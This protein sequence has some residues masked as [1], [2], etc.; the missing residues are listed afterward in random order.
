M[1]FRIIPRLWHVI[2]DYDH[3]YTEF[4]LAAIKTFTGFWLIMPWDTFGTAS[5]TKYFS[6]LSPE[7]IWGLVFIC[8]GIPQMWL[9]LHGKHYRARSYFAFGGILMWVLFTILSLFGNWQGVGW[10]WT[11]LL[12]LSNIVIYLRLKNVGDYVAQRRREALL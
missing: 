10:G 11:T 3:E 9:V 1:P 12:A 5:G 8:F 2:R 4:Q 6:T 7:Y